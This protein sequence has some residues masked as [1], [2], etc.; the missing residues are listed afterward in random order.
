MLDRIIVLI[1]FKV[2]HI[3]PIGRYVDSFEASVPTSRVLPCLGVVFE[4]SSRV[5][6]AYQHEVIVGLSSPPM[7]V[8]PYSQV[9]FP[10]I[11]SSLLQT[12]IDESRARP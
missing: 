10:S 2:A 1:T 3:V 6:S 4:I 7:N 12:W 11:W 9:R 5:G 8:H